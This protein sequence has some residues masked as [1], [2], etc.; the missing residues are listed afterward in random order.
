M[1]RWYSVKVFERDERIDEFLK[2]TDEK[3]TKIEP[4][5]K[6][7]EE[8]L[9]DDAESIITSQ[10]YDYIGTIVQHSVKKKVLNMNYLFRIRSIK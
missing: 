5:I 6:K 10:R 7:V 2:L 9:D 8:T 1:V 3:K 4:I